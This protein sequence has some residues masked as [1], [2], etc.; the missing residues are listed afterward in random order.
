MQLMPHILIYNIPWEI[1]MENSIAVLGLLS[2]I[3]IGAMRKSAF[4]QELAPQEL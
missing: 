4:C 3:S 2:E 1:G